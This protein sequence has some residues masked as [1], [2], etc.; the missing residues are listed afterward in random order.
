MIC[1]IQLTNEVSMSIY[2]RTMACSRLFFVFKCKLSVNLWNHILLE[3]LVLTSVN[4]IIIGEDWSSLLSQIS[5]LPIWVIKRIMRLVT[6]S[7]FRWVS[8][9]V[10]T[11]CPTKFEL[12]LW[13]VFGSIKRKRISLNVF[14]SI[15]VLEVV[16]MPCFKQSLFI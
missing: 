11:L 7:C 10:F 4:I 12:N 6:R 2:V 1:L 8:W 9:L 3:D 5:R 13:W 14:L 16:T 15:I